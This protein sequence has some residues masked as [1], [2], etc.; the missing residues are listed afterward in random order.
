MF[1]VGKDGSRTRA[2]YPMVVV[3]SLRRGA[4]GLLLTAARRHLQQRGGLPG[5]SSRHLQGVFRSPFPPSRRGRTWMQR[6]ARSRRYSRRSSSC[7]SNRRRGRDC[8]SNCWSDGRAS[9]RCSRWRRCWRL[10]RLRRVAITGSRHARSNINRVNAPAFAG[11]TGVTGHSPAQ[12]TLD[13]KPGNGDHC[14]NESTRVAAPSL[15]SG[16]R[17]TP[18]RANGAIVASHFERAT[19]CKD[20]LECISTVN[21][22]LKHATVETQ[23]GILARRF[24]IEV[25]SKG[26]IR[27]KKSKV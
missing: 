12:P 15:T 23:V 16:N 4:R 9:C 20:V 13:E 1:S 18:I 24:K 17:T 26:Q 8:R 10:A 25:V 14:R 19:S 3:A 2:P 6:G 21:A 27:P 5:Y 7:W 22:D 11:A